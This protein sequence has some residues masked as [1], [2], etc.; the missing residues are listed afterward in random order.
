MN[1]RQPVHQPD[2]QPGRTPPRLGEP[3]LVICALAMA[4]ILGVLLAPLV[5]QPARAEMVSENQDLV[6]M[7]AQGGNEEILFVLD[8]RTERLSVY[9]I[10]N[11]NS[12]PMLQ[13][14]ELPSLFDA[15]RARAIGRQ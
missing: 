2:S 6:A 10:Q 14:V 13:R 5:S 1:D 7:T 11:Q 3:A 15:A 12:M 9:K 8:N 4:I